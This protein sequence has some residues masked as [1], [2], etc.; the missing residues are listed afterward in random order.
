MSSTAISQIDLVKA[1]LDEL[2]R[3]GIGDA[4]V[5]RLNAVIAAADSIIREFEREPVM[6]TD[7]MGLDAWLRC[8][9]TGLS[10]CY[11]ASVLGGFSREYAH[12]HDV[13]DFGRCSR[14]LRS[15][16]EFRGSLR[17]MKSCSPQW[18]KLVE[19]WD[20][21]EEMIAIGD[22][23]GANQAVIDCVDSSA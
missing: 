13:D 14:L 5:W 17:V 1:I 7:D 23:D 12:P 3:Q 20:A 21:I 6:A 22:L 10:S 16:P 2:Q 4:E 9:D 18:A 19:R 15:V 8:D 11:M